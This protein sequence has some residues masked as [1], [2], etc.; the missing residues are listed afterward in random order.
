MKGQNEIYKKNYWWHKDYQADTCSVH[1][2]PG[3]VCPECG[4]GVLN[5]DGLFILSCLECG[6]IA[7]NGAFT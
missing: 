1:L 3:Y 2:M 5:Y 4:R 6:T 7:A